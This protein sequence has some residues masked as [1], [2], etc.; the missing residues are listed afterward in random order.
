MTWTDALP[1]G[2]AGTQSEPT[3][4]G[5]VCRLGEQCDIAVTGTSTIKPDTLRT[6][7]GEPGFD[8][9]TD[10]ISV[11]SADGALVAVAW[12]LIREPFVSSWTNAWVSPDHL[13]KGIGGAV[14]DWATSKAET[15]VERAPDGAQVTMSMGANS[16]NDRAR[17][18]AE[19]RGYHIGRYFLE[20]EVDLDGDVETEP[21]PDGI[22]LRTINTDEDVIDL[23]A[24]VT[25]SFRDHFGFTEAPPE[26][27]VERWRQ[28]R[29]SEMW[30]NE[31][32]W[33][34]EHEGRIVAMNV[35]L[36]SNGARTDQGYVA[37]LGVVPDW[38]GKGLA[39]ILLTTS[40]AEYAK[41]G[42]S[43][44]SLHVD[45]DSI[46]GATRLYTGVGMR[47]VQREI[48]FERVIR[49]GEDIV[50]R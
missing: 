16:R 31:L 11:R 27:R 14:V 29:T 49:D 15:Q 2:Y 37:T 8:P 34:A 47:E 40:F 28:W 43:S 6:M 50:M 22:T 24:A 36:R 30:E 4:L 38:R 25:E 13:G 45:A 48:D 10:I 26:I 5:E 42:K 41:R 23:S 35:C 44:V 17:R 7:F 12:F 1:T 46:T 20:M 9:A 3:D 21:L 32:V 18:L 19:R 33:L 39:R